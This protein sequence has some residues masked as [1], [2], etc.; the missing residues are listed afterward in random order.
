MQTRMQY[1]L[2]HDASTTA[3]CNPLLWAA[4]IVELACAVGC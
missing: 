4:H 1:L 3:W 2:G